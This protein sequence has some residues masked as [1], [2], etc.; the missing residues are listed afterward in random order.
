VPRRKLEPPGGKEGFGRLKREGEGFLS[1]ANFS[2]GRKGIITKNY[3]VPERGGFLFLPERKGGVISGRKGGDTL[4]HLLGRKERGEA[5][6]RIGGQREER[7]GS[8]LHLYGERKKD[9]S[10]S[11]SSGE[12]AERRG[13]AQGGGEGE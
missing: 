2:K 9:G 7:G 6:R 11:H 4:L 5:C 10:Y 12:K 1:G 13:A 8:V 3:L